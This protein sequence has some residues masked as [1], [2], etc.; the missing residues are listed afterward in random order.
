MRPLR[1]TTCSEL[2]P[3]F[4]IASSGPRWVLTTF[5]HAT[6]SE[7]PRLRNTAIV[8]PFRDQWNSSGRRGWTSRSGD[9]EL[10]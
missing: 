8:L 7:E 1:E 10:S 4:A 2:P 9:R 3:P 6:T 5:C